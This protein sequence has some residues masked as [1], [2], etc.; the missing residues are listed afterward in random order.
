MKN[1]ASTLAWLEAYALKLDGVI[2]SPGFGYFDVILDKYCLF[3][4]FNQSFNS[5]GLCLSE[6]FRRNLSPRPAYHHQ[7]AP[8][9]EHPSRMNVFTGPKHY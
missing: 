4:V 1:L 5:I 9:S 7:L 8:V 2:P 3:A 6:V